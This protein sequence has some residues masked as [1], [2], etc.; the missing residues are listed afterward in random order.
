MQAFRRLYTE[1]GT[2]KKR[3]GIFPLLYLFCGDDKNMNIQ[4]DNFGRNKISAS[5]KVKR[6]FLFTLVIYKLIKHFRKLGIHIFIAELAGSDCFMS[7]AAV[8]Q[9]KAAD[10]YV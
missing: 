5:H 1:C 8:F 6:S 4:Y 3:R 2:L 7:A 10:I 9:H